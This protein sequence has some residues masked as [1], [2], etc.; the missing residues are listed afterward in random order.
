MR[1]ELSISLPN[2]EQIVEKLSKTPEVL[3]RELN[4]AIRKSIRSVWL[5]AIP[6]TPIREGWLRASY[7]TYFNEFTLTG[8][9]RP[10]KNYAL[11]QHERTDFRHP[12]GGEAKYLLNAIVAKENEIKRNFGLA[13]DSTL[14]KLT[15]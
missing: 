8:I 6:R 14:S 1:F 3:K 2:V 13:I 12:K 10:E 11:M 15:R 7:R 9:L 5:E 4:E